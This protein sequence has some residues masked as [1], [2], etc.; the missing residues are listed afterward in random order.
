M[1]LSIGETAKLLGV[2]LRALRYYDE[3][4]LVK[5][6]QVSEAGYRFYDERAL[7]ALQ[8]TLF[9]RELGFSLRDVADML[10]RPDSDR[11]QALLERKALLLLER[12]RID[13]LIALTDASISGGDVNMTQQRTIQKQLDAQKAEYAKEVAA[14][15]GKTDAYAESLKRQAAR[16]AAD[17][18]AMQQDADDIFAAFAANMDK[19]PDSP[20]AQALVQRWLDHINRFYYPCTKQILAGLGKMYVADERFTETLDRFGD[21]NA[22]FISEAIA[23]FCK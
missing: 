4:G 14:R 9:Y 1:K 17:N 8:R 19:A 23:V 20:E 11:R 7:D 18:S 22:R 10:S 2:S 16:T 13:A 6:S 5:P 15:W 3:I 21:G 12:Q